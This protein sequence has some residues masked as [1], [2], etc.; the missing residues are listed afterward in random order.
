M[1]TEIINSVYCLQYEI[2]LIVSFTHSVQNASCCPFFFCLSLKVFTEM[3]FS[4][5]CH[6]RSA[7]LKKK[8]LKIVIVTDSPK[9]RHVFHSNTM[10]LDSRHVCGLNSD[11]YY[12]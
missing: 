11:S 3:S 9:S 1:K 5:T 10:C 4:N 8:E 2:L 7:H 6:L 12:F